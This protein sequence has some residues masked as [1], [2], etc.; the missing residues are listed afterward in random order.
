MKIAGLEKNSLVDYPEKIAAVVFTPGC[1]FDCYYCH[2]RAIIEG[3]ETQNLIPEADVFRFLEKRKGLLDGVVVSG[4]EPTLQNDLKAFM[5]TLKSLGYSVKLDTNGSN[6]QKV[7][8]LIEHHLV[9]YVAM[10]IKGPLQKY[11]EICGKGSFSKEYDA[12]VDNVRESIK[13][14]LSA[15]VAYEFRTTFIPELTAD[16]II[17]VADT[18]RGARLYVLQQYR[19]PALPADEKKV[20]RLLKEPHSA[21]Y[22]LHTA[23]KIAGMVKECQTRGI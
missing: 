5:S 23:Q 14:L 19:V 16:D 11:W 12:W 9:D 7:R 2:N 1:N 4:G 17:E 21:N 13:L 8:D 3:Q 18:I 20:A 6:P 10:D 15:K 22:V